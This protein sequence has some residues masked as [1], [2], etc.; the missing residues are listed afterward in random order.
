M[1]FRVKKLCQTAKLPVRS[2]EEAAGYDLTACLLDENGEPRTDISPDGRIT[3]LPGERVLI[4]TG[5]AFTTPK[6]TYGRIGPRSGLANKHG[7][8]TLAG[9]VDR[10]YTSEAGVILINLG[11]EVFVVEHNMRIAQL[12]LEKIETPDVEEV[13]ELENTQRGQGGFGS[14]GI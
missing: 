1:T 7:L 8:D 6:G 11:Q 10:D 3:L 5:L 9:I 14:T 4:P 2:S 13:D 12:V